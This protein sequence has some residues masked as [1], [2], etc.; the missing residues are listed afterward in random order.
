MFA[1][2]TSVAFGLQACVQINY[3]PHCLNVKGLRQLLFA[4]NLARK[5]PNS[6]LGINLPGS[7]EAR[8]AP[9]CFDRMKDK[10][11]LHH[12]GHYSLP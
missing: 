2:P 7:G 12:P 9:V 8:R 1:G 4:A 6:G 11:C 10:K 3:M 5:V